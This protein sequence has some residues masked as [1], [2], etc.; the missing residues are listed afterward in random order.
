MKLQ[1][2][3]HLKVRPLTLATCILW[4]AFVTCSGLVG[5]ETD[6][7]PKASSPALS[8]TTLQI[9]EA[10]TQSSLQSPSV[11]TPEESQ[12]TGKKPRKL[13]TGGLLKEWLAPF[14]R[15][16]KA[17][18]QN[19]ASDSQRKRT[20]IWKWFDPTTP[21][22]EAELKTKPIDWRG[23]RTIPQSF[24]SPQKTDPEGLKL[25]YIRYK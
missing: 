22:S 21:L 25:F 23:R 8:E 19:Q 18:D 3:A 13:E 15:K 20:P 14:E 9:L 6:T 5:Q 16:K 11:K 17:G 10:Q 4:T 7:K 2:K 24:G 12:L 1:N